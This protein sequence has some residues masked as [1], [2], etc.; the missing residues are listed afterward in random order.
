MRS[1]YKVTFTLGLQR[2]AHSSKGDTLDHEELI[3]T[4]L[5][6]LPA[7]TALLD[8]A[9]P[10]RLAMPPRGKKTWVLTEMQHR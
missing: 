6:A 5:A 2:L 7:E 9:E 4:V 1:M 3:N 10:E 8:T